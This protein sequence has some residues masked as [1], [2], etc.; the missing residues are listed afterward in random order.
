MNV[1]YCLNKSDLQ[2]TVPAN[3]MSPLEKVP[4]L[5]FQAAI[6]LI[7]GPKIPIGRD[8]I[9][10][11]LIEWLVSILAL[12]YIEGYC[13]LSRNEE[14]V[15]LILSIATRV[16]LRI[17]LVLSGHRYSYCAIW[18]SPRDEISLVFTENKIIDSFLYR[19]FFCRIFGGFFESNQADQAIFE[20]SLCPIKHKYHFT[21]IKFLIIP[22]RIVWILPV[23]EEGRSWG[24]FQW[25]YEMD[26]SDVIVSEESGE[27]CH[28]RFFPQYKMLNSIGKGGRD[29]MESFV[30]KKIF[31]SP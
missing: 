10:L 26:G 14:V 27:K 18:S 8:K 3:V 5:K 31:Y 23:T 19:N 1:D 17:F 20:N 12:D 7:N 22:P 15:R 25:F 29:S 28:M 11:E 24:Y 9:P 21:R 6:S 4:T 13:S 16:D 2:M 30:G